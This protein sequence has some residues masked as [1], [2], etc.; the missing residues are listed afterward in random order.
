MAEIAVTREGTGPATAI[1]GERL[2][3][4]GAG[5]FL[6]SS[7]AFSERLAGHLSSADVPL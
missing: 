7:P 3:L 2:V 5:H 4:P 6:Q 1:G